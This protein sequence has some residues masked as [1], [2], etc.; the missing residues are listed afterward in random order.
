MRID[1]P[2]DKEV[3]TIDRSPGSKEMIRI[4]QVVRKDGFYVNRDFPSTTSQTATNYGQ[5]FTATSPCE[6]LIISEVHSVA[7]TAAGTVT[8]D[9]TKCTGTTAIASGTTLLSTKFN[10]KSTAYTPVQYSGTGLTSARQL[11]T[12]DRLVL[13]TSGTLTTLEGVQVTIYIKPL[14]KGSYT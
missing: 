10:L 1:R 14:G 2:Q 9:V 4:E 7:G 8:L 12:G 5:I 3:K 11:A 6:V 13:Q